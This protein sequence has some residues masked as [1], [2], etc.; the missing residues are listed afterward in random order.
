MILYRFR[1][2]HIDRRR[3]GQGRCLCP[4]HSAYEKAEPRSCRARAQAV[5][6]DALHLALV[7]HCA[8]EEHRVQFAPRNGLAASRS[9]G[10]AA[11]RYAAQPPRVRLSPRRAPSTASLSAA[12]L[13]SSFAWPLIHS[14]LV[15]TRSRLRSS[16]LVTIASIKSLF[17]TGFLSD[18]N[19]PLRRQFWNQSVQ[20]WMEYLLSVKIRI[21]RSRGAILMAL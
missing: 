19:H 15:L 16:M 6:V 18:V 3:S 12:M 8:R 7:F 9:C 17:S 1:E 10:T 21:S 5:R 13:P 4:V 2:M 14:N 20:H 11:L